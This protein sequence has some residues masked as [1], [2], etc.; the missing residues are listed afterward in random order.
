MRRDNE[1]NPKPSRPEKQQ[2]PSRRE[3]PHPKLPQP[4]PRKPEAPKTNAP[5][6]IDEPPFPPPDPDPDQTGIWK[7]PDLTS[8]GDRTPAG[9]PPGKTDKRDEA[10]RKKR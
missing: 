6:R 7:K 8:P 9:K 3:P 1:K 10:P 2:P 4:K 5:A